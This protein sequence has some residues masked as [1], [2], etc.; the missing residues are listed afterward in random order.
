MQ[1]QLMQAARRGLDVR[2]LAPSRSDVPLTRWA[3][4]AFCAALIDAGVSIH[5]YLPRMLHAKTMT[6]DGTWAVLG[7]SNFDYRSFLLNHELVF[8][9]SETRFCELLDQ[10][11]DADLRE[12][13]PVTA[14]GWAT[15]SWPQRVLEAV[16]WSVRRWL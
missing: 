10:R 4:H 9:T 3:A 2:L 8:T 12:S 11:F 14:Q 16:G 15:R 1:Q 6:V 7:T 13:K 5:E